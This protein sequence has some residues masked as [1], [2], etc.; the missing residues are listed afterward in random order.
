MAFGAEP[1]G[2]KF[3]L[4]SAPGEYECQI[5]RDYPEL[6]TTMAI[7]GGCSS[8]LFNESRTEA[9]KKLQK[10]STGEKPS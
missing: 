3:L 2:C 7:G 1:V 6:H 4:G 10:K 8:T 9:W 5:A